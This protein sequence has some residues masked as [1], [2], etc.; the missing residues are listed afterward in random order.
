ML[1]LTGV[2]DRLGGPLM[3]MVDMG[4]PMRGM[5]PAWKRGYLRSNSQKTSVARSRNRG[6]PSDDSFCLAW[7][8]FGWKLFSGS[9]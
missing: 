8:R 1:P 9:R 2:C 4:L 3:D 7:F 6:G 5:S